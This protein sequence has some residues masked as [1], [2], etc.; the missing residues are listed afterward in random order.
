MRSVVLLL[1]ALTATIGAVAD[2]SE[3]PVMS[4]EFDSAATLVNW[5]TMQGDVIDGGPARYGIEGGE[6]V[7]HGAHSKWFDGE[8]AFYLWK[9]VKPLETTGEC[10][11]HG[12]SVRRVA[13][14]TGLS[15]ARS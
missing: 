1:V 9:E 4:D 13:A 12:A 11:A 10:G 5:H 15:I 8:R 7:V 6:L 14:R 2:A 3:L